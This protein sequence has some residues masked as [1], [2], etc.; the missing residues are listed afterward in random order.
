M[1][2]KSISRQPYRPKTWLITALLAAVAVGYALF[3]FMPLQHS[4]ADI[5]KHS[6]S[7]WNEGSKPLGV[8][9]MQSVA[10]NDGRLDQSEAVPCSHRIQ[11]FMDRLRRD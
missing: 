8:W 7:Q 1:K 9:L 6:I 2:K 10:R 4:E 5:Q 3:V 11:R